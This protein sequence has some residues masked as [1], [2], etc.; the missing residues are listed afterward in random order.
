MPCAMC[1]ASNDKGIAQL[2]GVDSVSAT[3]NDSFAYVKFNPELVSEDEIT[4]TIELRGYNVK[5]KL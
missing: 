5:V 4:K 1:E 2:S 3:L